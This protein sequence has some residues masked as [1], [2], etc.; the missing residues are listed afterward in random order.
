MKK[1]I[2]TILVILAGILF[3][4]ADDG[5]SY[6]PEDWTYGNIYV[7]EPNTK[8]A[9]ENEVL[10]F[11]EYS[12]SAVFD[13]NNTTKENVTV[14]CSF[15]VVIKM[16]FKT[17]QGIACPNYSQWTLI[18]YALWE[19]VMDK[20][21]FS[22]EQNGHI[23][24]EQGNY[25]GPAKISDLI[26][27][28]KTL[29]VEKYSDYINKFKKNGI[30]EFHEDEEGN[31]ISGPY[32]SQL[33]EGYSGCKIQQDGKPVQ[34]LNVGIE[35][36]VDIN[37]ESELPEDKYAE[38]ND[39][40]SYITLVLHFYHELKFQPSR[41]ATVNV[42]YKVVPNERSY[43]GSKYT[44]YYDISTGGTWKG[45]M[46]KFLVA[47]DMT[48]EIVNG[49]QEA[50]KIYQKGIANFYLFKNYKPVKGETFIF[51]GKT[52]YE[53][54]GY[55][56]I[57]STDLEN[58]DFIT[59]IGSS[60]YL[61]GSYEHSNGKSYSYGG[62]DGWDSENNARSDY[63]PKT[64]FDLNPY[65]GWVEGV[66]GDGK[67]EWIGFTL[68]KAVY[69]PFAINGLTR[70]PTESGSYS[71]DSYTSWLENNRVK[72][73]LLKDDKGISRK[74][75]FVDAYSG[76]PEGFEKT[77]SYPANAIKNPSFLKAGS[78]K[79]EIDE[80]YKGTKYDDT[81]LGEVWFIELENELAE[82][83]EED[84]REVNPVM[85]REIEKV[86]AKKTMMYYLDDNGNPLNKMEYYTNKYIKEGSYE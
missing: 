29:R 83:L 49:K 4:Y 41:H 32:G 44:A 7:K 81:V 68:K 14:P 36:N 58:N 17:Y 51:S 71:D 84:S 86:F 45:N 37:P 18:D 57:L 10:Y 22:K 43:H 82:L 26:A 2:S 52:Y 46:K 73:M 64:S 11:S 19:V 61:K 74:L 25:K 38:V 54:V 69:G 1:S 13:F 6:K 33:L 59:G 40:F 67:G 50:E 5:G 65:N 48:M 20:Q 72:T 3:L 60:S 31:Y 63:S 47:S 85:E 23:L 30:I 55:R 21:L 8:I 79:M 16:P 70:Y 39:K 56:P 9:L 27:L 75:E 34:I 53:D 35:V 66:K 28:D 15:P 80:V 76:F 78:Y 24:I 62:K 12:A 77:G 42:D